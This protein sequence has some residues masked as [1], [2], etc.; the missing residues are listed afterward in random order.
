M[1]LLQRVET[2][3]GQ[4]LT[5]CNRWQD[6]R[7]SNDSARIMATL[8][9]N[10]T[11]E[12]QRSVI[13]FL[14]SEGLKPREIH[15]R[16]IQQYSGSFMSERKVYQWVERF[17]EGWISVIDEHR[18]GCPCTAGFECTNSRT[19][20]GERRNSQQCKVQHHAERNWSLQFAVVISDFCLEASSFSMTT[21]NHT[22]L[23]QQ[24]PPSRN[25]N[26]RL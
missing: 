19:L 11:R 10:C 1:K 4:V 20:S 13:R 5:A 8:L 3:I 2:S 15:R 25:W 21:C 12:E 6:K 7:D 24:L 16:M 23:L 14:W 18:S 9:E 17:Q 26:L 22:L